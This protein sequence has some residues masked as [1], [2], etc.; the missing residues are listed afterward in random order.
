LKEN[1]NNDGPVF[2]LGVPA[3]N[4]T[5]KEFTMRMQILTP[6][7]FALLLAGSSAS[8]QIKLPVFTEEPQGLKNVVFSDAGEARD[9]RHGRLVRVTPVGQKEAIQGI[10]VRTDGKSGRIYVRTEPGAPPRVFTDKEIAKIEKGSIK[11]ASHQEDV[12]QPEIRPIVIMNGSRRTVNYSAPTLS[13]GE[14]SILRE[15]EASENA[16]AKL[17]FTASRGEIVQNLDIAIL[18]EHRDS[19]AMQNELLWRQI[20]SRFELRPYPL[21][22]RP[23]TANTTAVREGASV[24]PVLSVPPE[25][26]S[27][28]RQAYETAQNRAI[29]E[30]GRLVAVVDEG[31]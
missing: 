21:P 27:K 1:S 7:L 23:V 31:K 26:L 25:Q 6:S 24:M 5:L 4:N 8:A 22:I 15:L 12:F 14:L 29:F 18:A 10:L 20:Y 19:Q 30:S 3:K 2:A 17:E 9:F 28:A 16:L 11:L 13:P